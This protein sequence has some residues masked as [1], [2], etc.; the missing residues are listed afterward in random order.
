MSKKYLMPLLLVALVALL[1]S[2]GGV[3]ASQSPNNLANCK[4]FAFSTEEDFL[5]RGPVPPDGNPIISD[6]DLLGKNHAVCMRNR[7]LLHVHD[8]DPGIDLGLD[9]ADVLYIDRKLVAFSTSLD[10]PGKRFTAGDLLTTWGAVIPNR[11]LLILF[12]IHGDRGLDAVHFVGDWEHIIA[13]NDFAAKIPREQWLENPGLLSET[14]RR[15][16][17]DIWFSIEGTEQLAATTPVYDGDLLSA[18]YGVVVARNE[19]LLPPAVPAGIQ[20]GGVDFGL[21]A[22]TASRVFRPDELKPQKGHFSTEILYQGEPAFTDGDVLRVGD[23]IAYHD[24]DLT[25]PFEPLAD[26][27]GTDAI[28]IRLDEPSGRDFLPMIMKLLRGGGL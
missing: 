23:G 11:A 21:D 9:A 3:V 12:Q 20:T 13:F 4:D 19:Q 24:V 8:V 16:G 7:D 5:S 10:A 1:F 26:F 17:I 28:Y 22:F 14:L 6:G 15:N 2:V 25:A 27:L 18:A